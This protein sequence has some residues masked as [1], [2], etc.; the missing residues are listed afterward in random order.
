MLIFI[1]SAG[2]YR[3]DV[4]KNLQFG[5]VGLGIALLF[6]LGVFFMTVHPP[7]MVVLE[8]EGLVLMAIAIV[9]GTFLVRFAFHKW[10][11]LDAFKPRVLVLG[12]GARVVEFAQL[13]QRNNN[14]LIVGY[15][16][17]PSTAVHHVP[18]TLVLPVAPDE[19]LPSIARKYRVDQIVIAVE[20]RRGKL[21][22]QELVDCKLQGVR[23][24]E[25]A[26]S[27]EREY[28]RVSLESISASWIM[29]NEG[30]LQGAL[31]SGPQA[32]V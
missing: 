5:R 30:F 4:W 32:P 19:S 27:F 28:R 11:E 10:D 31:R 6:G 22:V 2:L 9:I 20:D 1:H 23:V 26:A 16:P 14:L 24:T 21:P 25:L 13:A 3:V 8:P 12:T 18:A 29:L 17:Y 15:V 7:Q